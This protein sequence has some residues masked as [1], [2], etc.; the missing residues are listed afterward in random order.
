MEKNNIMNVKIERIPS[1]SYPGL[2]LAR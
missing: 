2:G 1:L